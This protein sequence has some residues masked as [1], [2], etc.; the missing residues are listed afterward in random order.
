MACFLVPLTEALITTGAEIILKSREKKDS[1]HTDG[2]PFSKKLG[3]LNKMLWGGS[4]LLAFEHVWHG[5]IIP[6]FPFL[7]AIRDGNVSEMLSEMARNGISMAL[8]ITALWALITAF[9]SVK[10]KK[11]AKNKEAVK[12]ERK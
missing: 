5:E 10:E 7:T 3:W 12:V 4:A 8:L 11:S 9:V 6:V 2:L 1:Y